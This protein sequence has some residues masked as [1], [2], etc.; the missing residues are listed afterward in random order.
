[1]VGT[2]NNATDSEYARLPQYAYLLAAQSTQT[3]D[4]S[5]L[6]LESP[7]AEAEY[8]VLS[9]S[10]LLCLSLCLSLPLTVSV[11]LPLCSS[12]CISLCQPR[13]LSV[14]HCALCLLLYLSLCLSLP[15]SFHCSELFASCSL[16]TRVS[17]LPVAL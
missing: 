2:H 7:A 8:Q 1:M 10:M 4:L 13:S 17:L 14:S 16:T 15:S 11:S 5:N 3:P 6:P 12:H 9:L